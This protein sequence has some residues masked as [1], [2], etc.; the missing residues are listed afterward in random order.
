MHSIDK[1]I[2]RRVRLSKVA[3][4]L[5]NKESVVWIFQGILGPQPLIITLVSAEPDLQ[6]RD[7]A[8]LSY[9]QLR[10]AHVHWKGGIEEDAAHAANGNRSCLPIAT[11]AFLRMVVHATMDLLILPIRGRKGKATKHWAPE[12]D[13]SSAKPKRG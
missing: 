6:T 7:V 11:H 4:S 10:H 8:L 9:S 2:T 3:G 12:H 5:E 13:F 1:N